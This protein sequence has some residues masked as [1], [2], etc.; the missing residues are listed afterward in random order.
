MPGS[1]Q[2]ETF[3]VMER[4]LLQGDHQSGDDRDLGARA[5]ARL[6]A[7]AGSPRH[8][9]HVKLALVLAMMRR[10]RHPVANTSANSPP[11]GAANPQK[12]F[13]ILN[14]VP[15]VLMILIVILAV[16]KPF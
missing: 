9:L 16:V 2:S 15:T 12:F 13:R 10:A 11:T 1:R 5:V 14:E 8:W 7:A 3:K 4:R 6:A